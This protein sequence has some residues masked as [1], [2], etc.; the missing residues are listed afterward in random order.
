[1]KDDY[2]P[3]LSV[4]RQACNTCIYRK[5]SPLDLE[6]LENE[7][8]DLVMEGF[9]SGYRICHHQSRDGIA[10]CRGFW[11]RHKDNFTLGQVAQRLG[12]IIYVEPTE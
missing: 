10:V 12:R 11:N 9:F 4:M 3:G 1:M 5:D 6:R 2:N 8:Q 7:V